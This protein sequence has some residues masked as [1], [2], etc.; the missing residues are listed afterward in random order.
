MKLV[1]RKEL[2]MM[3]GLRYNDRVKNKIYKAIRAGVIIEADD[4][5][6]D[7]TVPKNE[8]WIRKQIRNWHKSK[9][10]N[11]TH[12]PTLDPIANEKLAMAENIMSEM[13]VKELEKLTKQQDLKKK[14][15]ETKLLELREKKMRGELIPADIAMNVM[16]QFSQMVL[17]QMKS[18][19]DDIITMYAKELNLSLDQLSMIGAKQVDVLNMAISTATDKAMNSIDSLMEVDDDDEFD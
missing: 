9:D 13:D 3:I 10:A 7:T 6:V 18:G 19:L 5:L 14:E 8:Q 2:A 1:S 12:P 11:R 16:S 17:S 15:A 4:L